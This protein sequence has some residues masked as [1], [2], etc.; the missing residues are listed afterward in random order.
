MAGAGGGTSIV[1][2]RYQG[3]RTKP[4][5]TRRRRGGTVA[6][7]SHV[8]VAFPPPALAAMLGWLGCYWLRLLLALLGGVVSGWVAVISQ[9]GRLAQSV[10]SC[11]VASGG[12]TFALPHPIRCA[13][14]PGRCEVAVS[15]Q[16]PAAQGACHTLITVPAWV[17][18]YGVAPVVPARAP[19]RSTSA[20]Y[21]LPQPQLSLV[22]PSTTSSPHPLF[23][24]KLR[25]QRW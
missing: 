2:V 10:P 7:V 21:Q 18:T 9:A 1:G 12:L 15:R 5:G 8:F 17:P 11:Q 6:A 14:L 20:A 4:A 16:V 13:T 24:V 19:I 25:F 23:D 3:T 22:Y